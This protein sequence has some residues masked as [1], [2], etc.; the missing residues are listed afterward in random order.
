LQELTRNAI[1]HRNYEG[2]A[3]PVMLTW[4]DDRVEITSPG[5]P[6]GTITAETFGQPGLTDARNPALASAAKAMN[7]VQRFGSG[8][9]RAR[10]ALERNGNSLP[11]F[12]VEPNFVN[13]TI[14]AAL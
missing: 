7:F 12:R 5:G 4:Y 2:V 11:E 6:Y 9:P 8:I 1:I 14:R 10:A 3:S 13:V